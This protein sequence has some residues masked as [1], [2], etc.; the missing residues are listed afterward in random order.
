[1]RIRGVDNTEAGVWD[2]YVE[3]HPEASLY[4]RYGWRDF[5]ADYF[6]KET[7]YLAAFDQA[8]VIQGVLP[9]VRLCSRLF[10]DFYVSL[11]F[12]NYGG[13]LASDPGV[14]QALAAEA[15]GLARKKGASHIE[16]R[17][18]AQH[19]DLP[20]R[21]D[22]VAMVLELPVS[23]E[24]LGKSIGA[25]RRSQIKRPLRENPQIRF[26][27]A[28]LVDDFYAVFAR[29]MRD[30]GTPVYAKSMFRYLAERYPDN[31]KVVMIS[32]QGRPAAAA[33]LISNDHRMEVPW[34]STVREFNR[35]SINMLL[36]WEVLKHAIE[37]GKTVF[38]F[39]RSTVDSGTYRF[40]KQ[41]GAEPVQL[42]WHYWL[43]GGGELP[44][45]NPDNAR[46]RLAIQAWQKLPL[47]VANLL[48]PRIVRH[49]P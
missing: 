15:A 10:G 3:A 46:Y 9:L 26:G 22:K 27:G 8:G 4:H 13:V 21:T 42:H 32:V 40:K 1:M 24:A 37:E 36:Y 5:F 39:G 41:W 11:P 35:I 23:E 29:N 20:C 2:A 34:A 48:G 25:K 19:L 28:E 38:D 43:A 45:L 49:L 44:R 6:G 31:T 14:A 18:A 7:Q 30:L 17:H 12:V 16:Y 47:P 33:F